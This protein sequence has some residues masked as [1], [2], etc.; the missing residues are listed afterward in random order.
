MTS[1]SLFVQSQLLWQRL[2]ISRKLAI[3]LAG[4]AVLSG[5]ATVATMTGWQDTPD[6]DP[7]IVLALLYLDAALLLLLG[8]V[9]ARR[10]AVGAH[11]VSARLP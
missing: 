8:V 10:R 7:Q 1:A 3:A 4:M 2:G 9:V 6:P 11:S 5:L